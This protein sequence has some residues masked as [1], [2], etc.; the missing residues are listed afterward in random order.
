[1]SLVEFVQKNSLTVWDVPFNWEWRGL[2][3]VD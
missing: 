2:G 1:M 3:K